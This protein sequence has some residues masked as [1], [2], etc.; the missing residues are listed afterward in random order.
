M[1]PASDYLRDG[2][3]V[4]NRIRLAAVMI[5]LLAL[6]LV[7][8]LAYIQIF[9]HR[10]FSTLAQNNRIT[11]APLAPVRGLIY[12]RNGEILAQNARVYNLEIIP[13]QVEDMPRLLAQLG[14]LVDLSGEEVGRFRDLLKRRP[15]FERRTLRTNLGEAEAARVALHQHRYPGVELQARLQRHY[16][17]GDLTAHVVG[18]VGRI[19]ADDLKKIDRQAYRGLDYI[20]RSGIEAQYESILRGEAGVERVETNAHG[21]VVQSLEQSAPDTGRTVHLSL[22]IELQRKSMAA[23]RGR[24][25][26]IVALDPASGEVLAF[27]GAPAFDPNPFVNGISRQA[28]ADLRASERKPLLNRALYGRYAPGS[29]IKGFMLL[30]GLENGIDPEERVFCPGWFSLPNHTHR[31]RDWKREGHGSMDGRASIVQSCDVY[32]Y[33]LARELGIERIHEGMTRFGFG[34]RTGIDLPGEPSGLVPSPEW[35]RRAR[36]EAWFPGE[37]V[38]A[39]IGQ[40]YLLVTPLQLA[41]AAATV[42]NHGRRITPQFL[43]ALENP[44]NRARQ[45]V[46]PKP[47]GVVRLQD[48]AYYDYLID[49]MREVVHGAKGTAREINRGL[50]YE[51]AGKTGTVQVKSIAQNEEYDEDTVEKRFADHSLFIAFA[52]I[53]DPKIAI[54]VIVEHAGSGS[55]TAAPIARELVDYY[56]LERLGLFPTSATAAAE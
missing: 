43:F 30:V 12:D 34:E 29:V 19:N 1:I 15:S 8:R 3:I 44:Q 7:A 35:K 40:G 21:K 2:K 9:Q 37:T 36:G 28:Y 53:D 26:A 10:Q 13:D 17:K 50:R 16:P 49:S 11:L 39:G 5:G 45:P 48:G 14:Q 23:L 42:A 55:G 41:V 31:Y 24:E 51:M 20:G 47:G 38:I 18:Y 46:N 56:L 54:A 33:H 4:R 25:G 6:I 22:D 32:F 27:A 52:P